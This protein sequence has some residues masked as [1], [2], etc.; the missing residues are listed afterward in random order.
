MRV[1]ITGAAGFVGG[2]LS[3]GLAAMHPDWE[4]VGLDNLM[5]RGSELNL[6]RLRAAGVHFQHGDVREP[7]DLRRCGSFDALIECS[8]EPSVLAGYGD[9]GYS[10]A[11][12]LIGAYHCLDLARSEDA[13]FLFLSTSRVYP[14]KAQ[15]SLRLDETPTR[16]ELAAGQATSGASPAGISESFPLD[17]ARSLYGATKLSAELLI[18]EYADAFALRS[19]INRCGV[20][21]GPWQMGK[22]DQG[23]F[24]WWLLSHFYGKPLSYIGFDGSGKQ[25]RDL[26]HVDDVLELVSE[27]LTSP[28]LWAGQ[29]VNVG[30]GRENS[31]SLLETTKLCQELTGNEVPIT[32]DPA[33][34]QGDLPIYLSDCR[35]LESL[36]SWRPSRDPRQVLE[37]V[38]E[39]AGEQGRE[40]PAVLGFD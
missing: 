16:F 31:L 4:I 11:T 37:D 32:P 6:S 8:A 33:T 34:R 22:V 25:V 3:V 18:T 36:T 27:Q 13:F 7:G 15:R 26:L 5:R 17:G 38:L 39:W 2:N 9:T 40:L 29:T 14:I 1:L 12:N 20:I 35:K 23:V 10:V 21:A 30:G 24:A 19:V 28:D